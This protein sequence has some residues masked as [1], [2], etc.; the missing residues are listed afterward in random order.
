MIHPRLLTLFLFWFTTS[1][2]PIAGKCLNSGF[3]DDTRPIG[4]N[5]ANLTSSG[6][7]NTGDLSDSSGSS[8]GF[9]K[10]GSGAHRLQVDLKNNIGPLIVLSA[11]SLC[12]TF[13]V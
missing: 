7:T 5:G 1:W 2:D 6:S 3:Q 4:P 13:S 11:I 12:I 8:D 10:F 9:K